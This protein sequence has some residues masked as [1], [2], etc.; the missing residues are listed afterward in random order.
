MK[1]T[2]LSVHKSN[3]EKRERRAVRDDLRREVERLTAQATVVA[4]ALVAFDNEGNATASF[5]TGKIMPL[6]AFPGACEYVIRTEVERADED[7]K[8][9]PLKKDRPFK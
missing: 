8:A 4:Y 7:F 6:W 3:I 9:K 2:K 5:D 1:P